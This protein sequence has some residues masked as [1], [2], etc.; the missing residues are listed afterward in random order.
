MIP[1]TITCEA[2]ARETSG[3][4]EGAWLPV[5]RVNGETVWR[6][7]PVSGADEAEGV[8]L[9]YLRYA[10]GGAL[11]GGEPATP[12]P[13][14]EESE[15]AGGERPLGESLEDVVEGLRRE[16]ADGVQRL[17]EFIDRGEWRRFLP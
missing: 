12:P 10:L 7:R 14:G 9:G 15:G 8:A 4:Q 5:L 17:Q 16:V 3:P 11:L 6:G 13:T 2:E 1:V